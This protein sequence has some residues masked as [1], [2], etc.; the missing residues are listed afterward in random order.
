MNAAQLAR[1]ALRGQRE[2]LR[3]RQVQWVL[4]GPLGLK[5]KSAPRVLLAQLALA[6]GSHAR[7]ASGSATAIGC[8]NALATETTRS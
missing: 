8:G 6:G 3:D 7:R 1:R 5:G 4:K 2:D